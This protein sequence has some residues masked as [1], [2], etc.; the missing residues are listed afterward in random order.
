MTRSELRG[1]SR[2]A[3]PFE[4]LDDDT[5]ERVL[6][7]SRLVPVHAGEFVFQRGERA[8]RFFVV[9]S[10]L[11]NLVLHSR[12]GD[13]KVIET[14]RPNSSFAETLMF[15]DEP[16]YPM[17][18]VAAED[19]VVL[20]VPNDVYREALAG[21][22]TACLRMLGDVS[23]RVHALVRE[24]ESHS[25]VDAKTRIVRHLLELAGPARACA[26]HDE[27]PSEGMGPGARHV[28]PSG[29]PTILGPDAP[30][31]GG[32]PVIA[33]VTD[34]ARDALAQARP[35]SRIRFRHARPPE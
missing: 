1:A 27:H 17:A 35:G 18:A 6:R 24:V 29:R 19:T 10:G 20:A 30:V 5:H 2:L 15:D 8:T 12:L 26:G 28:P 3:A 7:E 32:Y 34:A 4:A 13:E 23:R 33:V 16:V 14:L 21:S 9:L 11:V 22:T 31:T 25:L